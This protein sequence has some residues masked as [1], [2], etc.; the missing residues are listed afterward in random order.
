MP[1]KKAEIAI[2]WDERYPVFEIKPVKDDTRPANI[3]I[4]P[5]STAKRWKKIQMEWE[6]LQD[7]LERLTK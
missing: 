6:I 5:E 3:F 7:E 1:E 2:D 4:V